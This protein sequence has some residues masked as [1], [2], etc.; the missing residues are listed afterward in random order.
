M[1]DLEVPRG[2]APVAVR[3]EGV[4]KT[5]GSVTAV[6]DLDLEIRDPWTDL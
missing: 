4:T 1:A 6:A 2:P 3:L 5:F